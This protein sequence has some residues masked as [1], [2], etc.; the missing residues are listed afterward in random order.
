MRSQSAFHF[1]FLPCSALVLMTLCVVYIR[2]MPGGP[3][4]A[5]PRDGGAAAAAVLDSIPPTVSNRSILVYR[6]YLDQTNVDRPRIRILA[7]AQC[8]VAIDE[9][10]ANQLTVHV[11]EVALGAIPTPIEGEC[12]WH[13]A[14]TCEWNAFVFEVEGFSL[15]ANRVGQ[16]THFSTKLKI[17]HEAY[18]STSQFTPYYSTKF[19][20]T[21]VFQPPPSSVV[22]S[23]NAFA[24]HL[25]LS[26]IAPNRRSGLAVCVPPLYWFNDWLRLVEFLET[27]RRLGAGHFYVYFH[28]VSSTVRAVLEEY[29]GQVRPC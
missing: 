20:V 19:Y 1:V 17:F 18:Y 13:W 11:D 12:P 26:L 22:V 14:P 25:P 6:A 9:S 23:R 21:F 4:D 2:P 10:E 24:T 16:F 3:D 8:A 5:I 27:W 15:D 29:S 7:F 28:S